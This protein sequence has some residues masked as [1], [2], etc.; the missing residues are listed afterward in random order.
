MVQTV[1]EWAGAGWSIIPI[2]TK[3]KLTKMELLSNTQI[4]KLGDR[5]RA[6]NC[7]KN[8]SSPEDLKTQI[9]KNQSNKL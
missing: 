5:I 1:D 9:I 2:K 4:K 6:N 8:N 7:E 3:L